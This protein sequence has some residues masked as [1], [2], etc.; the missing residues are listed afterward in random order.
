MT[1][2]N[3]KK[4]PND[5][6]NTQGLWEQLEVSDKQLDGVDGFDSR[7]IGTQFKTKNIFDVLSDLVDGDYHVVAY[8]YD[9]IDLP[10]R[11]RG[12]DC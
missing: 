8:E 7:I 3:V 2:F 6:P 12:Y 1:I 11:V 10:K 9:P 5:N 4:V